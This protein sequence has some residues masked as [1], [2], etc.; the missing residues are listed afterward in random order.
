VQP[1]PDRGQV[2]TLEPSLTHEHML[3][4]VRQVMARLEQVAVQA[5]QPDPGLHV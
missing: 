2:P 1:V 4:M 5:I 3:L